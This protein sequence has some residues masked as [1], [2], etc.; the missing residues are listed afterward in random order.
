MSTI[1]DVAALAGVSV[2][3]V[4]IVLNGKA[5]ERKVAKSTAKK[6]MDAINTL[7]YKPNITARR[8]QNSE[9]N[10]PI[11]AVY[12]PLDYRT[13][14]LARILLGFQD[15]IK[16]LN[17]DCDVVACTYKNDELFKESGL[18][19][20]KY[21][22]VIIG[23]ASKDDLKFLESIN[24]TFPIVLYNR[25]SEKYFSVCNDDE[26]AAYKAA[27]LFKDKGHESVAVFTLEGTHIASVLRTKYFL[28]AC[29]ELNI[30]IDNSH[31]IESENS[32]AGGVLSAK[33]LLNL[34]NI[35]KALFCNSDVQAIG[36]LYVFNEE[37]VQIPED[38]EVIAYGLMSEDNTEYTTPPLTVVS[39]PSK[40][41]AAKCISLLYDVFKHNINS[42]VQKVISPKIIMRKSCRI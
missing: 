42:P 16:R 10:K 31:I 15:E 18:M 13:M 38:I 30:T 27:M 36:A 14:Y 41:M 26:A 40:E 7:N 25:Y 12:W 9:G 11:I 20:Y 23:G 39:V 22:A 3:T 6:V 8:L 1:K 21:N 34:P 2:S 24:A 5:D 28:D 32:Y 35:P 4:S 17:F 29:K 37:K 33:K 19:K